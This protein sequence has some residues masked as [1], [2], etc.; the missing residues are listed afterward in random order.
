MKNLVAYFAGAA[1]DLQKL[2]DGMPTI[3][4]DIKKTAS[5]LQANAALVKLYGTKND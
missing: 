1:K 4:E 5:V 2:L 3:E